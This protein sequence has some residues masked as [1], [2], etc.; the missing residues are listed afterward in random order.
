[1]D[2]MTKPYKVIREGNAARF[3]PP[4]TAD[5]M[6]AAIREIVAKGLYR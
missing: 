6:Q 3:D 2:G 1:M 5:R 4:M